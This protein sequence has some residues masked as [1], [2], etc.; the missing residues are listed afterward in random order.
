MPFHPSRS[1]SV[2]RRYNVKI[3]KG[4]RCEKL[5]FWFWY[6][7]CHR[8]VRVKNKEKGTVWV[9]WAVFSRRFVQ[10]IPYGG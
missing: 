2:M 9:Q 6:G 4:H 10:S 7:K 1:V 3:E 8:G 5:F